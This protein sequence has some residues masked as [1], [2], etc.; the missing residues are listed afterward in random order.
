[1]Q[2]HLLCHY[3]LQKI[4]DVVWGCGGEMALGPNGFSFKF[5]KNL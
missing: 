2:I 1:M 3:R 5:I 4:K